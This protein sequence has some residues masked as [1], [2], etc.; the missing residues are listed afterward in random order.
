VLLAL[1]D[2]QLMNSRL[3]CFVPTVIADQKSP[4]LCRRGVLP[5]IRHGVHT[6]SESARRSERDAS[7][8]ASRRSLPH[9]SRHSMAS[10]GSATSTAGPPGGARGADGI[11]SSGTFRRAAQTQ[12]RR[13]APQEPQL[14]QH[15][16]SA[17]GHAGSGG[18]SGSEGDDSS[19]THHGSSAGLRHHRSNPLPEGL[20]PG[21]ND[22]ERGIT[23][24][25][26]VR[27]DTGASLTAS[28]RS[29]VDGSLQS[30]LTVS[31]NKCNAYMLML[32]T[33]PRQNHW[34]PL[35]CVLSNS[36]WGHAPVRR[37]WRQRCWADRGH[38]RGTLARGQR[39]HGKRLVCTA[40]EALMHLDHILR[41]HVRA[42]PNFMQCHSVDTSLS[43]LSGLFGLLEL[44][45]FQTCNVKHLS[46][47]SFQH[48][49]LRCVC[50]VDQL[51]KPTAAGNIGGHARPTIPS[52]AHFH[53]KAYEQTS[54]L[55]V[56]SSD[57]FGGR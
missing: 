22:I 4:S 36:I 18:G 53:R 1:A 40:A 8:P 39:Q 50:S 14:P 37:R 25:G 57:C 2:V 26:G 13:S 16:V 29:V 33:L 52:L 5:H 28:L 15:A 23:Y 49:N 44:L 7:G 9:V 54:H 11:R 34:S 27:R 48:F 32:I 19:G 45:C 47:V 42:P 31:G 24:E 3:I 43:L 41:W 10:A 21:G 46:V 17:E 38:G 12:S 20:L 55:I 30:R 51:R 6:S 56:T 35:S